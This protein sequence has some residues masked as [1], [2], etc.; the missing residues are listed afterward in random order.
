M[1][2]CKNLTA[3]RYMTLETLL[4]SA[5]EK[6][7]NRLWRK[8]K[9]VLEEIV[10]RKWWPLIVKFTRKLT[11]SCFDIYCSFYVPVLVYGGITCNLVVLVSWKITHRKE[12]CELQL[13]NKIN[14][15]H[16]LKN[17][18]RIISSFTLRLRNVWI[19]TVFQNVKECKVITFIC[20]IQESKL[21][22]F[23]V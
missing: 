5:V 11:L 14:I 21:H 23:Y 22:S 10:N 13:W 15:Q 6:T 1:Q 12:I 9:N 16:R 17:S 19:K 7:A 4:P 18:V 2:M 3:M 20:F 8:R